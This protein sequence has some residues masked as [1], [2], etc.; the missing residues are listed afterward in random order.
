M[1]VKIGRAQSEIYRFTTPT[2]CKEILFGIQL[3]NITR[4]S[5]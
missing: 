3:V 4:P 1:F 5:R 2:W